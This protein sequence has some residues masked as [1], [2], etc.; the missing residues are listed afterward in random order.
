MRHL[1]VNEGMSYS[2]KS[3]MHARR[4]DWARNNAMPE[5][6]AREAQHSARYALA[7]EREASAAGY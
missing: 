2:Q 3:A 1:R 5:L 7:A 6:A 4:A